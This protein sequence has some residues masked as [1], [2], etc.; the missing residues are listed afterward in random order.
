MWEESGKVVSLAQWKREK[1]M[2][3]EGAGNNPFSLQTRQALEELLSDVDE[4]A[5][6][7]K[8]PVRKRSTR[9]VQPMNSANSTITAG[10]AVQNVAGNNNQV[11]QNININHAPAQKSTRIVVQPGPQHI[12]A[13]Q[14]AEVR[15]LV[16]KVVSTTGRSYS[17]VWG[18]VKRECRFSRYD[19]INQ[20]TYE[21]VCWYLRKWIARYTAKPMG[22]LEEQRKNLLKRIHAEARKRRGALDQIRAYVS[23]RFGTNSLADLTPGQLN[24]VIREFGL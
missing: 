2:Q 17:F 8:A 7:K 10:G 15:E 24:E 9:T 4:A 16:A 12:N 3:H 6:V 11:T 5:P 18:T 20:E 23:G 1:Q 19:L 22:S 13:A 14:A 21:Q